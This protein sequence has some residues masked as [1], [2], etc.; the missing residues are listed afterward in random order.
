M[1]Y[2]DRSVLKDVAAL[3]ALGLFSMFVFT[4]SSVAG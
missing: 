2:F 3:L 1:R 4:L